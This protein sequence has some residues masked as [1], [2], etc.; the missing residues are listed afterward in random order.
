MGAQVEERTGAD[1]QRRRFGGPVRAAL[2][3]DPKFV[4]PL[5]V[6][7]VLAAIA[8][9]PEW[10]G[11]D[12]YEACR[13]SRSLEGP[14]PVH[15]FGFDIQGCDYY[16][17]T[18]LGARASLTVGL[19]VLVSAMG[20]G[21]V[22][23]ALAGYLE[24]LLDAVLG[25]AADLFFAVPLVLGGAVVLALSPGQ[26]TLKVALVLGALSWP[27]MLRLVR[28][29]VLS[30]KHLEY[31]LAARAL[32]A[33]TGRVLLRHV[34]PA[35]V[36]PLVTYGT[37]FVGIA[38]SAEA[39]LSFMG[40]GL[41]LPAVSWGLQLAGVQHRV[42]DAPHLL[43]PGA[44]LTATVAAFVVLGEALRTAADPRRRW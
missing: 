43:W 25:R 20:L 34:L 37:V 11:A 36:W 22:L 38:I 31:V 44:F 1:E 39:L 2:A 29:S 26:G 32:G 19:V 5:L 4:V 7:G 17:R 14:S 12:P 40:V 23:G 35:A 24:G 27:P 30:T 6:I 42:I 10:F 18:L 41:Q 16:S 33:G 21:L 9:R 8:V 13:L 28:A 15:P 3:R